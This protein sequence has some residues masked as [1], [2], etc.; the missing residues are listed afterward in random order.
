MKKNFLHICLSES[1]GGLEMAVSKWNEILQE[2]GH[3]NLNIVTPGSP[4]CQDLQQKAIKVLKWASAHY[5]SPDFTWKLRKLIQEKP[6]DALLLQNLRDLWIVSP[7]LYNQPNVQLIGFAQMLLGVKKTDFLHSLVYKRLNHLL[8]LTDWQ[9]SALQPYLPV[10]RQKYKTIPNFVD[11]KV[12]HPSLRSDDFRY[13]LGFKKEDFVIGVIG[14]ID[15]QKGQLELLKAFKKISP[16]YESAHLMII[17]E[18]TIGEPRQEKYFEQLK[19]IVAKEKLDKKVHFIGFQ[20][21]TQKYFANFDL[22]V[23]PSHKETFG[24]VVVEAMACGT[25]VLGTQAG[26]VPEI[27]QQGECGFLC[28]PKSD[29]SIAEQLEFILSNIEIRNTKADL[30]LEHARNFY[31]RHRVYERFMQVLHSN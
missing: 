12:F 16:K 26:G 20:K 5:F 4:L 21:N 24:F 6:I 1:W 15:E 2:K 9:I 22:F 23:L 14:R 3:S 31:D 19:D 11:T 30:A 8:T 25:P 10:P 18:P 28:R 7:A 13:Q 29:T 17:G 27:L